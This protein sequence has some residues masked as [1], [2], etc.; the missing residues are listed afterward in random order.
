MLSQTQVLC[1]AFWL[2]V[3]VSKDTLVVYASKD[4]TIQTIANQDRQIQ[5]LLRH[6]PGAVLVLE[7][8]GV[9]RWR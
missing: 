3:D 2:G 1:H 8:T 9:T 4:G 6:H 5:T 7:A